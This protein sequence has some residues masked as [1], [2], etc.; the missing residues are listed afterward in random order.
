MVISSLVINGLSLVCFN[1]DLFLA[2]FNQDWVAH[3]LLLFF[4]VIRGY[5]VN[6][7]VS[8]HPLWIA[9]ILLVM[10]DW[11]LTGW[12]GISLFYLVFLYYL[13]ERAYYVLHF[14]RVVIQILLFGCAIVMRGLLVFGLE[15]FGANLALKTFYQ[16]CITLSTGYILFWNV[17][18]NR[19]FS[20]IKR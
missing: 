1:I 5:E 18:G 14:N 15:Y 9:G 13:T 4:I 19:L 2:V 20:T 6:N 3:T 16:I 8:Q 11:F 12:A 17:L 7:A 10:Q